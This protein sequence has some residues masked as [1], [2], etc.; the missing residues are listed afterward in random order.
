MTRSEI[1]RRAYHAPM[2]KSI[3]GLMVSND[4]DIKGTHMPTTVLS[5]A[6]PV[7]SAED[8]SGLLRA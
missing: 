8:A 7:E 2:A 3:K 5:I 1:D 4:R 6:I